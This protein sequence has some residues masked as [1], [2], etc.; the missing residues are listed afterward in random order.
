[1]TSA[2]TSSPP[3]GSSL[4]LTRPRGGTHLAPHSATLP[5]H[6]TLSLDRV[7]QHRRAWV[8]WSTYTRGPGP[9][10]TASSST[11]ALYEKRIEE[12]KA[13][14]P[15]KEEEEDSSSKLLGN[16][17]LTLTLKASHGQ[18]GR[19]GVGRRRRRAGGAAAALRRRGHAAA[20]APHAVQVR[21]A[22]H[23]VP[24][25]Q[26]RHRRHRRALRRRQRPLRRAVLP[27]RPRRA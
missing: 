16:L 18:G 3:I 27:H 26:C 7:H 9:R 19:V 17:T 5:S 2:T 8:S 13:T 15:L 6:P 1:M 24:L 12:K 11:S 10:C 21:P 14:S 20:A 25:L 22:P 4:H 23:R